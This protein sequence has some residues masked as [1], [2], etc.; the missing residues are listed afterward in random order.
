MNCWKQTLYK[1]YKKNNTKNLFDLDNW[2][3]YSGLVEHKNKIRYMRY[4]Y[5]INTTAVVV[6]NDMTKYKFKE[7]PND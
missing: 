6:K 3:K 7:K 1:E 5:A 4:T 2:F